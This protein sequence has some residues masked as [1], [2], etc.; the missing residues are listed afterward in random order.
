MRKRIAPEARRNARRDTV[1][2]FRVTAITWTL[3]SS[4]FGHFFHILGSPNTQDPEKTGRAVLHR[5]GGTAQMPRGQ[6]A[7]LRQPQSPMEGKVTIPRLD[8]RVS[9]TETRLE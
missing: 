7:R 8:R 2:A 5:T 4:R 1:D 6:D 3:Q 9:Q